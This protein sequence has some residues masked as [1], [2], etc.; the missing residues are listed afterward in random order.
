M[1]GVPL[2][3]KGGKIRLIIPPTLGYGSQ[4]RVKIPPYSILDFDVEVLDVK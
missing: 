4:N 2:V 3:K 1:E